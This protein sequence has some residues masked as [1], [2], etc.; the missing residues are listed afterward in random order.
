M[1]LGLD[2]GT[3]SVKA[4]LM[5][6]NGDAVGE[7][8]APYPVRAPRPGWAES[9]PDEWWAAVLEAV[10]AVL[11][12]R[13][14]EVAAL[15]LSGQMHGV[16]LADEGG[17]PLRP[18]VLWADARSGAA[19]EAYLG[20][21]EDL[22]RRLANPP[23]VGMAGPSL[24][25]L[26]DHEPDSYTS[27]RW[28]LQPKD[29]LRMR[30]TGDVVAEPSDASATLLYDL[31]A[32]DWS[33]AAVEDLG[34]RAEL[35]APLVSS[36]DVAGTLTAEAAEELGLRQG[37]PV[38]AGAADTAAAMLGVGL[39]RPGPVQ[40][41]IGTGGQIVTPKERPD[42][43][44]HLRTHLY[45]GA[46]PGLWY[47]MAAIQNAGLA[48]EW[49]RKVL[50][51]SWGEV[52]KEAFAVPPGSGGVAFLPYLSGER[53]PRFDPGARG[54]WTGLG[55]EHTRGHLLRAALEGVAFALREGLEALEALGVS[56][57][58]VRLAGGGASGAGGESGDPWRQLLADVLGRP[59]WLLPDE[60]STVASARGA[61]FLAGLA[62]DVYSSAGDTLAL[63]PEPE[64][65]IHPGDA[66]YEAAYER[67]KELYPKLYG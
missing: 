20:L 58:E 34:L 31:P 61:A 25:W 56:A 3:S 24:L 45:R 64:R 33:H 10:E 4:L 52:Y 9:Y 6:E 7:G 11:G 21:D 15:G 19:L 2:L 35:L 44:P 18:A 59:L 22:R 1:L 62:S 16:V 12:R 13:G 8:S 48:L 65:S 60:I 14:Q 36:A 30:L 39:S 32:D 47:A 51:V 41:T 53:T 50:G 28:A 27:A 26:R 49:V 43:D 37:L 63:T 54:A 66:D 57:P 40:L 38:A 17:L 23:A 5:Q 67:Y 46:L 42:V 29:W 55:L